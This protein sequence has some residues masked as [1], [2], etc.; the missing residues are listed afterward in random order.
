MAA[1]PL[2]GDYEPGTSGWSRQQVELYEAT[3]VLRAP[4]FSVGRS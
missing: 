3:A 4:T 2:T 1:M